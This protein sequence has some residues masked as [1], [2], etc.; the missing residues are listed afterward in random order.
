MYATFAGDNGGGAINT[1]PTLSDIEVFN[2]EDYSTG[3]SP[4]VVNATVITGLSEFNVVNSTTDLQVT[5]LNEMLSEF[6][7]TGS[8]AD[9]NVGFKDVATSGAEALGLTLLGIDDPAR[10]LVAANH[11]IAHAPCLPVL[12]E[13]AVRDGRHLGALVPEL[14]HQEEHP[15]AQNH[16]PGVPLLRRELAAQSIP[17][18]RVAPGVAPPRGLAGGFVLPGAGPGAVGFSGM[19]HHGRG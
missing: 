9:F 6:S 5:Q 10:D 3:G 11:E 17:R 18:R 14:P 1:A 8:N 2:L 4:T 12:E 19:A 13:G 7:I 15:D 16:V